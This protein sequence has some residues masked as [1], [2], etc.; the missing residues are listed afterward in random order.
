MASYTVRN[1]T[2]LTIP[3]IEDGLAALDYGLS[4]SL[5]ISGMNAVVWTGVGIATC[6]VAAR[7]WIR[8][9]RAGR[10]AA[11]DY[12]IFSAHLLLVINAVLQTI[13]NPDIYNVVTNAVR[14]VFYA[15]NELD[16]DAAGSA[17]FYV[18]GTRFLK[19]E[20]TII[21][22]FW[23]ILWLVKA[24]FLAFFY[25]LFKGLPLYRRLWWGVVIFAFLAYAGCWIASVNNC[26]PAH[27]YFTFGMSLPSF[28][29]D[30]ED[31]MQT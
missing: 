22:F 4:S 2:T 25:V 28:P 19:Y 7:A 26:H 10:L 15:T 3:E 23:T 1:T 20:F 6:F 14:A 9:V 31:A 11:D 17:E 29:K 21:G 12:L 24:S 27:M 18:R 8:V 5:S 30:S 16:M 13:Q